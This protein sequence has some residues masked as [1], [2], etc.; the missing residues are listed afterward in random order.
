MKWS[1]PI[2]GT[3][4]RK[5]KALPQRY[6]VWI[7]LSISLGLLVLLVLMFPRGK[8]PQFADLKAGSISAR[9]IVAPFSFEILKTVEEYNQDCEMARQ[10]V[11]PVYHRQENAFQEISIQVNAFFREIYQA[12]LSAKA[13]KANLNAIADSLFSHYS[14]PVLDREAR[15]QLIQPNSPIV[16][17][18]VVALQAQVKK[19]LQDF[20]A[21][22]I[23]NTPPPEGSGVQQLFVPEG[24]EKNI[25]NANDYFVLTEAKQAAGARL[26]MEAGA[27][28]LLNQL[29]FRVVDLLLRPTLLFDAPETQQSIE[30]EVARVPMSSGFVYENEKI[31]DKNERITPDIRK[32]LESLARKMAEKGMQERGMHRLIPVFGRILFVASL[33]FILGVFIALDKPELLHDSKSFLLMA[34]I[35]LLVSVITFVLHRIDASEYLITVAMGGMLFAMLFDAKLGFAGAAVMSLLAGALWGNTFSVVMVNFV[36]GV[37]GVQATLRVKNRSRLIQAIL[38]MIGVYILLI[39]MMG[40]LRLDSF[41]QIAGQLPFGALN[42]LLVPII[43]FGL[44]PLIESS[45]GI[46]TDFSLLELSNFNHPL[47]KKLSMEAPGTY[48]HSVIVGN[49]AEAAAQNIGANSLLARVGSYYHDIGKADKPEYFVENQMPGENPH[50]K[51][52][53]R[54][55]ALIL[56]NHVKKGLELANQHKLPKDIMNIITQHQGTT[57]MSFFYNKALERD[58]VGEVSIED[59]RYPGPRPQTKEAAVVMLADVVEAASRTLKTPTHSRLKGLI[60]EL[61]DGR[62]KE[63]QLNESP[64]TL[65]DMEKI[66]ESF[67]TILAGTFHARVEYPDKE[68]AAAAK[69]QKKEEAHG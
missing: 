28:S 18:D 60:G 22:D 19:I 35:L 16:H 3:R 15:M 30:A 7:R 68:D 59:Y 47:L 69:A 67:L 24:E 43:T 9:R 39:A 20:L 6:G 38:V 2:S 27:S 66:K 10:K 1:W 37:V 62:F 51:L 13:P 25:L 41:R 44:L 52:M 48:H 36:A 61:V 54:M 46:T 5:L 29:A 33:L 56:M 49:L 21:V 26:R 34:L 31:V 17:A 23:L 4:S 53:P 14:I 65:R 12:R 42:G 64:L 50:G 58:D 8:A 32:K 63:G 40:F 45:F 11:L 57:V 55:S